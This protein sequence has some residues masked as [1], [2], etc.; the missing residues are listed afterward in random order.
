M[1]FFGISLFLVAVTTYIVS[2]VWFAAG[3]R[4]RYLL[5]FYIMGICVALW[6]LFNGISAVAYGEN[7]IKMST[8]AMVT[9]CCMPCLMALYILNLTNSRFANSK[10]VYWILISLT[11]LD[12][13][14][15]VTDPIHHLFFIE[16]YPDNSGTYGPLFW[17]H[18]IFSYT[19][20]GTVY[21]MLLVYAVR[22]VRKYPQLWIIPAGCSLPFAVNLLYLFDIFKFNNFDL[23]PIGFAL[24]AI[25]CG[26]FSIRY[27]LFN[28][29][30]AAAANVFD[31]VSE[32]FLIVNSMGQLQDASPAFCAAFS[33]FEFNHSGRTIQELADHIR[34]VAVSYSPEDIFERMASPSKELV[35]CEYT[36]I[37]GNG[38]Q[39]DFQISKN[40]LKMER[41]AAGFVLTQTD[42]SSHKQMIA[43]INEQNVKLIELKDEAEAA[44]RAK[45]Q[46]LANM[47]HEMRTPMNA[48]IGMAHIARSTSD[49]K[50]ARDSL[51]IIDRSS[52][53]LLGLIN[54]I[55]DMSKIEANMLELHYEDFRFDDMLQ[56]CGD[57]IAAAMQKKNQTF[58][59]DISQTLHIC[60]YADRLRLSQIVLNLLSNAMKFTPAGGRIKLSAALEE[61]GPDSVKISIAV[62]D[63]GIGMSQEQQQNLFT[64]FQQA[65]GSISRRFGGTGLGLAISKRLVNMMGGE[66]Y[67]E[68]APGVGSTFRFDFQAQPGSADNVAVHEGNENIE[69]SYDFTGHT[70]LL[71]EDVEINRMIIEELLEPAGAKVVSAVN[72]QEAYDMFLAEPDKY[73]LIFMD[74]Q[75]PVVDGYTAT[76][77]IRQA[78]TPRAKT[79]PIIAMT[80]NAF[81]EDKKKCLDSGMDSH[82][83]KPIDVSQLFKITNDYLLPH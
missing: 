65:D 5:I 63:N 30:S 15:L 2:R 54:D 14:A 66:V 18:S 22:N 32:G 45:G 56:E 42:V 46:F 17:A 11:V 47:S 39:R 76:R 57:T 13:I 50:K 4:S 67:L 59:M 7:A 61:T 70:L 68:S 72:G 78:D 80:A 77:M 35:D 75:M 64:A 3:T 53:Q 29:K 28:L 44:S 23:T 31:T 73:D 83:A 49:L 25:F 34:A 51:D 37:D 24:M 81:D 26:I 21:I 69:E 1:G 52:Q 36:I 33:D 55:L 10:L 19:V 41:R 6:N 71:A 43:E 82:L 38:N 16:R 58:E 48:I 74:V 27:R 62:S 8:L 12:V 20:F 40:F 79:I 60:L 9:V